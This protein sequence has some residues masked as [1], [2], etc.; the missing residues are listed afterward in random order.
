MYICTEGFGSGKTNGLINLI[1]HQQ[2]IDKSYLYT[3]DLYI[4]K[5]QLLIKKQESAGLK[6]CIDP[7]AVVEY[8][9]DMRDIYENIEEYNSNTERKILIVFDDM[10]ADT[11]SNENLQ[12]IELIIGGKTKH[13][14]CI[15]Y[16]ILFFCT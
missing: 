11:L 2:D 1:N 3:E 5:Y 16:T 12:P 15:Y 10:T 7:N 4:A 9:N 6:L 13:S 14:S 8:L